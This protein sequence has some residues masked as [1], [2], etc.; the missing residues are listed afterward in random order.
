MCFSIA[1]IFDCSLQVFLGRQYIEMSAVW[2]WSRGYGAEA[3][4]K[5]PVK[6][7][8]SQE[9]AEH[10]CATKELASQ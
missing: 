8:K 2:E 5:S 6:V 10:S 1:Q 9:S 4:D 7:D 3:P